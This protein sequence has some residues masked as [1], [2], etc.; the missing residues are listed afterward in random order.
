M[1]EPQI[2]RGFLAVV[3]PAPVLDAVAEVVD[4]IEVPGTAR[5]MTRAQWHVTLQF[6]GNRVTFDEI[7]AALQ[8]LAVGGGAVRLGGAGAFP[9]ER[10]ARVL[11]LGFSEGAALLAQIAAAIGALLALIGYPPEA[12]PFHAHLTLVRLKAPTDLRATVASL[13]AGGAVGPSWPVEDV[14]L[15]RSRTSREGSTYEER[16]RFPLRP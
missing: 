6:L 7:E 8:E 3:P 9:S 4:G 11:W 14:V 5:H 13:N 2:G 16:A 12:R 10:R 1:N 15:F